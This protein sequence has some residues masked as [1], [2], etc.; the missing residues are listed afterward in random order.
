MSLLQ[1]GPLFPLMHIPGVGGVGDGGGVGEGGDG[2]GDGGT[3]EGGV[4]GDGP[5]LGPEPADLAP[6][7]YEA[8][9]ARPHMSLPLT[10][11]I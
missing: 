2:P 5:G 10:I 11:L 4:G 6:V 7:G 1:G 3:G 9:I 8:C